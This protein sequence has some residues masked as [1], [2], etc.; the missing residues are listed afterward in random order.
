VTV[1]GQ[2]VTLVGDTPDGPATLILTFDG[3]TFT[4]SWT[5]AGMSGVMSGRRIR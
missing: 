4:G 3:D 2:R 1:E 5:Y